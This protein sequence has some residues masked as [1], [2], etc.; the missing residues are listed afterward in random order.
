[1]QSYQESIDDKDRYK[2]VEESNNASFRFG[3][4]K[5]TVS[6]EK[7]TFPAVVCN[8]DVEIVAQVV[9]D[10]ISLLISKKTMVRAEMVLDFSDYLHYYSIWTHTKEAL[11]YTWS[12]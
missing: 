11:N 9:D 1:M 7:I 12:L 3:D 6:Y 5:P 4:N 2:M 10:N 8:K